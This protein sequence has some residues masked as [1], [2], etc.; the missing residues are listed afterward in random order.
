MTEGAGREAR[1]FCVDARRCRAVAT[2]IL[3]EH[4]IVGLRRC[5]EAGGGIAGA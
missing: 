3:S 4:R 5:A 1:G 2:A